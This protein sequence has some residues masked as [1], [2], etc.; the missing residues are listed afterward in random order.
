MRR[1]TAILILIP[2]ILPVARAQDG[3]QVGGNSRAAA[4]QH[5]LGYDKFKGSLILP[6]WVGERFSL[7]LSDEWIRFNFREGP[8]VDGQVLPDHWGFQTP[9]L[10]L[11]AEPDDGQRWFVLLH[12]RRN[13]S[14]TSEQG[15]N[16]YVAGLSRSRSPLR[17][18]ARGAMTLGLLVKQWPFYRRVLPIFRQEFAVG[19]SWAL[20][21]SVPDRIELV[22]P[23]VA[24]GRLHLGGRFSDD[25]AGPVHSSGTTFWTTESTDLTVYGGLDYGLTGPLRLRLSLGMQAVR[26]VTRDE[27]GDARHQWDSGFAPMAGLVV[28]LDLADDQEEPAGPDSRP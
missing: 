27:N 21:V 2:L 14:F 1:W 7:L 28:Y 20:Q 19:E 22:R 25:L 8:A 9:G 10:I 4:G 6:L 26:L 3:P 5:P 23:G 12:Q 17:G 24:G 15:M 13:L 18:A 16:R 11:L